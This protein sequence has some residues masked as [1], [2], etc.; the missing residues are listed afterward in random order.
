MTKKGRTFL[1]F[2]YFIYIS[3]CIIFYSNFW[4][5]LVMT[6]RHTVPGDFFSKTWEHLCLAALPSTNLSQEAFESEVPMAWKPWV[7]LQGFVRLYLAHMWTQKPGKWTLLGSLALFFLQVVKF[8]LSKNFS[9]WQLYNT[10][11]DLYNKI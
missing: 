10:T 4:T 8:R 9:L 5:I 1:Y 7:A 3:S 2:H 6:C 11:C